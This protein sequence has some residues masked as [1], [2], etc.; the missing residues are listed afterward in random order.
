MLILDLKVMGTVVVLDNTYADVLPES[1]LLAKH[2][3]KCPGTAQDYLA[4]E[5]FHAALTT[6]IKE[7]LVQ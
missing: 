5:H 2:V 4:R 7:N 6:S 3:P 1:S